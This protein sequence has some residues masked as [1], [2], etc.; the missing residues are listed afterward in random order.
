MMKKSHQEGSTHVIIITVLTLALVSAI[1]VLFWQ[2]I[3]SKPAPKDSI[4]SVTAKSPTPSVAALKT[5]CTPL[6]KMCFDYPNDWSVTPANVSEANDGKAE[7]I[8]ISDDS[9]K[10]W[11][12]LQTGLTGV[13]GACGDGG[14]TIE[15]TKSNPT[16][17]TNVTVSDAGK[18]YYGTT[19][20][21]ISYITSPSSGG[22]IND[23][24]INM[25]LNGAL[26]D[27]KTGKL[28]SLCDIG[29]PIFEG[30][31]ADDGLNDGKHGY[32]EFSNTFDGD[33]KSYR[34]FSSEAETRAF[35]A[36]PDATKAYAILQS[37]HYE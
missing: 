26:S 35:L 3:L 20:Y 21:A 16:K 33:N 8:A 2:N 15:I 10:Q 9:G 12:E 14:S 1:G 22:T 17:V 11:L 7:Q 6:E 23:W 37:A 34:G 36:Q 25:E 13:G 27:T 30:R 29:L 19:Q 5:Y 32:I 24:S 18:A 4:T 31:N 28:D